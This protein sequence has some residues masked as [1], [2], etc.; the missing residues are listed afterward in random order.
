MVQK[1]LEKLDKS[2]QQFKPC[3]VILTR[4]CYSRKCT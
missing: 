1:S 4:F 3:C 2:P